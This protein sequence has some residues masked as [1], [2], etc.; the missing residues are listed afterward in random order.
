MITD[1]KAHYQT[2]FASE[3]YARRFHPGADDP[4]RRIRKTVLPGGLLDLPAAANKLNVTTEKVRGFVRDGDLKFINIGHGTKY[5][6][7]RFTDEDINALIEKRKTQE[8]QCPSFAPRSPRRI[9]GS[10]SKSVV[11]GFMEA[12]NAR[13]ASKPKNSKP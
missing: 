6:R 3:E 13:I 2:I 10:V 12:R 4:K 1:I 9:S 7:Y 11:V 5:P 8:I